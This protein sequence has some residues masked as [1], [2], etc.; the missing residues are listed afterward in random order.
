M[1]L[2]ISV[3]TSTWNCID[4]I[5]DAI[6]SLVNQDYLFTE[7][8]WIDGAST[9]GTREY[10]LGRQ[11]VKNNI[12]VSEPDDGL[13]YALNKGIKCATGDVIGFLHSDDILADTTILSK[14]ADAFADPEVDA[15]Y[16]DLIYVKK[17]NLM[18]KV[19][20]W[21]SGYFTKRKLNFGWMPP[22]PALYLRREIY[23][24]IGLFD[25]QY[26]V[27]A[28]YDY[29]LRVFSRSNFKAKYIPKVFVRMRMG[30]VSNRSLVT[31]LR[32]SFEDYRALRKNKIGG[33]ASLFFKNINKLSQYW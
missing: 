22:H 28:D 5:G 24:S 4:T 16:G 2:K 21:R 3:I 13:Y 18:S 6:D 17:N 7:L 26:R 25:T 11:L 33:I 30:G 12:F 9:D 8:I 20:H 10:L 14:I 23:E 15:V 29:I 1:S 19:R 32:K 31:I 27:A